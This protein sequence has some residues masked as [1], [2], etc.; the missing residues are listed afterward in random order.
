MQNHV[1]LFPLH[2]TH[3]ASFCL[4]SLS[5]E[6]EGGGPGLCICAC[7]FKYMQTGWWGSKNTFRYWSTPCTA[8]ETGSSCSLLHMQA[9]TWVSK[10]Y[11]SSRASS[12][13]MGVL[14]LQMLCYKINIFYVRSE[15]SS[16]DAFR[17]SNLLVSIL[18]R[19]YS[20]LFLP[21]PWIL[22]IQKE[23]SWHGRKKGSTSRAQ[24]YV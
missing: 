3:H 23:A 4:D 9:S 15:N 21:H 10:D 1:P 16:T 12:L 13:N 18:P 20:D 24:D 2:H 6:R 22:H 19:Q 17:A 7:T 14:G 5:W 8:Y 11:P